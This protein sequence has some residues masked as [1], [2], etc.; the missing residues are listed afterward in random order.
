MKRLIYL[1]MTAALLVLPV[2]AIAAAI[3][4]PAQ[5]LAHGTTHLQEMG[6]ISAWG[7]SANDVKVFLG[8][9]ATQKGA[10]RYKII[11]ER[12]I[13]GQVYGTAILYK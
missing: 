8:T 13:E 6:T 1:S 12:D 3:E 5:E 4:T 9:E 10:T 11:S 2:T 7:D